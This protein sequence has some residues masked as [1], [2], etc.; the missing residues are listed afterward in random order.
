MDYKNA[1]LEEV[2]GDLES[3]YQL[4]F[5][6]SRDL[7]PM[8]LELSAY[9]KNASLEEALEVLFYGSGIEYTDIGG[10]IVLRYN[11]A[12]VSPPLSQNKEGGPP[13]KKKKTSTTETSQPVEAAPEMAQEKPAIDSSLLVQTEPETPVKE[14]ETIPQKTS[15]RRFA[16]YNFELEDIPG[17]H[18]D[19]MNVG[20]SDRESIAQFGLTPGLSTNGFRSGEYTN[21]LSVN[22]FYG[23]SAGLRGLEISGFGSQV[24]GSVT[25]AQFAGFFNVVTGDMRGY[26]VGGFLNVTKGQVQG[27][28]L[29][30]L[31]NIAGQGQA[32]QLG[33]LGNVV[34]GELRGVQFGGLFNQA[35]VGSSGVYQFAG[36][37]NT[38]QGQS[39]LQIAG[40]FNHSQ[41]A[42]F[43]QLSGL[44]NTT[45]Q[46]QTGVQLA[47]LFNVAK[48]IQLGQAA[49]LF[50]VAREV[51]GFQIGLINFADTV[52]KASI[53]LLSFVRHGYNRFELST[54]EVFQGQVGIKLGS[55]GFYNILQGGLRWDQPFQGQPHQWMLGYGLGTN[56][57]WSTHWATNLEIVGSHVSETWGSFTTDL[58]LLAQARILLEFRF[59]KRWGLFGGVSYNGFFSQNVLPETGLTGS[60]IVPEKADRRQLDADTSLD[61][62]LGFQAGIR[63]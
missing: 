52:G 34:A 47:G 62:W 23:S 22:I 50:N 41:E 5:S 35:G 58:N 43:A 40:L 56:I 26:Q 18:R 63:F 55:E 37:W 51:Q 20:R 57:G 21:N 36:L 44:F 48:D 38:N 16:A 28:Q 61:T 46:G 29:S 60:G 59:G 9:I 31:I 6:Y 32:F 54:T 7:L 17:L 3:R 13:K 33:G 30:T 27:A 49:A 4:H 1:S 11:P 2:I 39:N 25:G 10:Q 14:L 42:R 8:D 53:G 24:N 15:N 45:R 12:S 19:S